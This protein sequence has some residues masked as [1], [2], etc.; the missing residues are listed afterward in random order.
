MDLGTLAMRLA[1]IT[2]TLFACGCAT[3]QGQQADVKAILADRAAYLRSVDFSPNGLPLAVREAVTATR[4]PAPASRTLTLTIDR[5]VK[6]NTQQTTV[7]GEVLIEP[8]GEGFY[9][10]MT[11]YTSNGIP[12]R[13][14]FALCYLG[15]DCLRHQSVMHRASLPEPIVETV[16]LR[17]LTPG[18]HDPVEGVEY[19]T[20]QD[21][22]IRAGV[23]TVSSL[24][25]SERHVCRAGARYPASRVHPKLAG[26]AVDLNCEVQISGVLQ[27]RSRHLVLLDFGL[28]IETEMASVEWVANV[29]IVDVAT[30]PLSVGGS[31]PPP[32]PGSTGAP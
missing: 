27:A 26:Q 29:T 24:P 7:R 2:L 16:E 21:V 22:R 11:E 14:N 23:G 32:A 28:G 9:R 17:Q 1:S 25:N 19:V 5:T 3:Q 12:F 13:T 6:R 31:R 30:A 20:D 8:V 15:L 18:K 10:L 4:A